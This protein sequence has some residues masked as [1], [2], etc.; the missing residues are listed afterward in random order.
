MMVGDTETSVT[1]ESQRLT[2]VGESRPMVARLQPSVHPGSHG[3][4]SI[5]ADMFTV[6]FFNSVED[7]STLSSQQMSS[8]SGRMCSIL[9]G[10]LQA[11][12]YLDCHGLSLSSTLR[13][14]SRVTPTRPLTLTMF[15]IWSSFVGEFTFADGECD[16]LLVLTCT[17]AVWTEVARIGH[18]ATQDVRWTTEEQAL[19]WHCI[20]DLAGVEDV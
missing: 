20:S 13:L 8:S 18:R 19:R 16:C 7:S 14:H 2:G 11:S 12:C 9:A 15:E 10:L 5:G 1:F 17:V 4:S 6:H 3:I